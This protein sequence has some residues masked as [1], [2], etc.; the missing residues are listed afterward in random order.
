MAGKK[1]IKV[2]S[3]LLAAAGF[4]LLPLLLPYISSPFGPPQLQIMVSL[5]KGAKQ[6]ATLQC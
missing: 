1:T 2:G 3:A 6:Q 5:E 4:F